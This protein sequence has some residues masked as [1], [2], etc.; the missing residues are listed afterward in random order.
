MKACPALVAGIQNSIITRPSRHSLRSFLR[1]T[2]GGSSPAR[3]G[4]QSKIKSLSLDSF[5]QNPSRQKCAT[6]I[7]K[8][9]KET[10]LAKLKQT[11]AYLKQVIKN[12]SKLKKALFFVAVLTTLLV[13]VLRLVAFK[14]QFSQKNEPLQF[15]ATFTSSR[16]KELDLDPKEVFTAI[17]QDLNIKKLRL[18]SY[19]SETEKEQGSY[20]FSD[21]DWQFQEAE[22]NGVKISLSLGLRQPRWPECHMPQWAESLPKEA[23]YPKLENQI[24]SVVERY[25]NSPALESY[26]LE[27]EFFLQEFG[28]CSDFS[29]QRLVD[30]FNTVKKLDPHT[31]IILTRSNNYGGFALNEPQADVYGISIYRKVH[32][33]K[34]GYITYPFPAWYYA[35]LAQGQLSLTGKPSIIHE[36]QLEPWIISGSIKD[37]S[38]EKQNKTMSPGDVKLNLGFAKR[39]GIKEIYLW[40][41]EWWYWRLKQGDPTIWNTIK[42]QTN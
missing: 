35:F 24:I 4:I 37:S 20:D 10:A 22:K 12:F 13:L 11:P 16:A 5:N 40:G 27:N 9:Q 30:E 25:K 17:T 23:W 32:N 2:M 1:M 41:S 33:P 36:F 14:Y 39:T 28:Q 34:L 29:R 18:V 8:M 3:L 42:Q 19:W 15:G 6:I 31:P 38:I 7:T 21:L 26:Q